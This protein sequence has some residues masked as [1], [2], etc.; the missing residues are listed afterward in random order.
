VID[1]AEVQFSSMDRIDE[2]QPVCLL[3]VKLHIL[4]RGATFNLH[5]RVPDAGRLRLVK[6]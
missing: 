6:T 4:T 5:T 2:G 3:G 1:A